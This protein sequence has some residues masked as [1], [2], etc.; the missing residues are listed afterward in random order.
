MWQ[1]QHMLTLHL[2]FRFL[3]AN[4]AYQHVSEA[5]IKRNEIKITH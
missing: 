4:N 5:I 3:I 2:G 1:E